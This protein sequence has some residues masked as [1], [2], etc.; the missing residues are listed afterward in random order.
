MKKTINKRFKETVYQTTLQNGLPVFIIHKPGF[1][2][3]AAYFATPFGGLDTQRR[4]ENGEIVHFLPGSAHFLEHKL[5]ESDNRDIMTIFTELGAQVNAFTSYTETVYYFTTSGNIVK[6]LHLLLDFVQS[7]GFSPESIEKE[8]GIIIQ[9]LKMYEQMPDS[10]LINETYR[11]L[12]H[13]HPLNQDI[14]GSVESVKEIDKAHLDLCYS[15]NYHPSNMVL[16]V[17]SGQSPSKIKN[18]IEKN[19]STKDFGPWI[20]SERIIVNEPDIPKQR[21]SEIQMDIQSLKAT[22]SFK[23]NQFF[24]DPIE[25]LKKEWALRLLLEAHFSSINP[26]Y[27]Q[28]TDD[29]IIGDF[30][31]VESDLGIDYGFI[32]FYN[33]TENDLEFENF[34][35]R[36]WEKAT[37]SQTTLD[38]LKKRYLGQSIRSLNQPEDMAVAMMRS[39]F[40]QVDFFTQLG[41][42]ES[43]N[44]QDVLE[45]KQCVNTENV[46]RVSLKNGTISRNR[47]V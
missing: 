15:T 40:N 11:C 18:L 19:Q 30:F 31:G 21:Y 7:N 44:L 26:E 42:I 41:I 29:Q 4:C 32:L 46:C 35:L 12:Y 23:I 38:Q 33:E 25:R 10:R 36:E 45:I 5:F 17:A 34:V 27:Q 8:K 28:W 22:V 13:V 47:T 3:S 24:T 37:I 39:Y 2:S 16:V 9:E 1:K 20:Q 43:V 6:P 14:G